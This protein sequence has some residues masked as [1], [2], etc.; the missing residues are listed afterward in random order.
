MSKQALWIPL[1]D[2]H[3]Q[4]KTSAG[5]L[6]VSLNKY[7]TW[8]WR[9][10]LSGPGGG[11]VYGNSNTLKQAKNEVE[12]AAKRHSETKAQGKRV[13]FLWSPAGPGV[14][15]KT[16]SSGRMGRITKLNDGG[17]VWELL[18]GYTVL[19]GD[20]AKTLKSA[21]KSVEEA[22]MAAK[23]SGEKTAKKAAKKTGK[24]TRSAAQKANDKRLGEM[25]RARHAAKAGKKP[26]KKA[27]KKAAQSPRA[28]AIA[29]AAKVNHPRAVSAAVRADRTIAR[30]Q[31]NN[32][33][34]LEENATLREQLA[35]KSSRKAKASRSVAATVAA[36]SPVAAPREP[37]KKAA[38]KIEKVTALSVIQGVIPT[39]VPPS[40]K[41]TRSGRKPSAVYVCAGPR[42]TGCGG[43][44]KGSH[45]LGHIPFTG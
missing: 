19:A 6:E 23:K 41:T 44:K 18:Y 2:H 3:H 37:R 25:A 26:A 42:F 33:R 29:D 45:V 31:S 38:K 15:T 9:I 14:F 16:F 7:D 11:S 34:L 43:G 40:R 27:A 8:D 30:C 13:G 20:S 1:G 28:R 22:E 17:F 5:L 4:K 10:E 36:V 39:M 32:A 24:K 21:R 12:R 35:K